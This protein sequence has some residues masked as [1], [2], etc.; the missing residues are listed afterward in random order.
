MRKVPLSKFIAFSLF[1]L[2]LVVY[3]SLYLYFREETGDNLK[4]FIWVLS[5]MGWAQF[6]MSIVT[7]WKVSG[8][9]F[10]IYSIFLTISY[11]F[12]FGQCLMWGIGIHLPGEIGQARLYTLPV[13]TQSSIVQTQIITLIGLLCFH[14]GA[15]LLFKDQSNHNMIQTGKQSFD[16]KV[17]ENQR[18][19]L[20][21]VCKI[22]SIVSTPL[23]FYSIVRNILI[24]RQFG[25]GAALYNADVVASQ[26]NVILLLRMMYIPSILGLL[27]ASRY[28]K[29]IYRICYT[30]FGI[31]M[32]LSLF[33]GDRGEWLFP[34]CLIVWMHHKY[35]KRINAQKAIKYAVLAVLLVTISVAVRNTRSSGVTVSGI[36]DSIV[37][38]RNP[39]VSGFFE[40][41]SSM[42]PTL[43]LIQH[44]WGTY[45]YGNS[46]LHAVLGMV[47]ERVIRLYQSNYIGLSSWFSQNFLGITYGAGF[48]FIAE[49]VMN[50][51]PYGSIIV[52]FVLGMIS[53]KFMF[54]VEN[55][56]YNNSPLGVFLKVSTCYSMLQG[57]R[58]TLLTATKTWIFSTVLI[59]LLYYLYSSLLK[60]RVTIA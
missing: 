48:S 2:L 3:C 59:I 19:V 50:Y 16:V 11:L 12:T 23:M 31:F 9:F 54:S 37:G 60:R 58:N 47:T 20:F 52:L 32:V 25:Y 45:P 22:T 14:T 26:N 15:V 56:D 43:I 21:Q 34:L 29:N 44:G 1:V 33:A 55:M 57:I 35:Y 49:A 7:W 40:L 10:S 51:G 39:I 53:S 27:I 30:N 28:R 6:A 24:N 5:L 42:R 13:P 46:Y 8:S 41:G 4:T 18:N 17:V 38:E 36:I